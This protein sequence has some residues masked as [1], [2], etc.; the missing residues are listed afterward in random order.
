MSGGT[1]CG[2][3]NHA[4]DTGYILK[5]RTLHDK[6]ALWQLLQ[7]ICIS[8]AKI[9]ALHM[10]KQYSYYLTG[11][12]LASGAPPQKPMGELTALPHTP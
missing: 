5:V 10:Y 3:D 11:L 8:C 9:N 7:L 12:Y 2:G 4:Y 6:L 1:F